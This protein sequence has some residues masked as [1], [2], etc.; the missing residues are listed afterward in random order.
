VPA[1]KV[2]SVMAPKQATNVPAS[3]SLQ[4]SKMR[5]LKKSCKCETR[6]QLYENSQEILQV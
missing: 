5:T 1:G 4:D 6:Q 2:I 3:V